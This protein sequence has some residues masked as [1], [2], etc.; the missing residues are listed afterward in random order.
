[1][2]WLIKCERMKADKYFCF[3]WNWL[4]TLEGKCVNWRTCF[5]PSIYTSFHVY[6]IWKV[7]FPFLYNCS[8][9]RYSTLSLMHYVYYAIDAAFEKRQSE[10]SISFRVSLRAAVERLGLDAWGIGARV[11]FP[12]AK[13]NFFYRSSTS[14]SLRFWWSGPSAQTLPSKSFLLLLLRI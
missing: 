10:G 11:R 4:N 14:F 12:K 3:V 5:S 13:E 9:K 1:M 8:A 7:H 2:S 6:A